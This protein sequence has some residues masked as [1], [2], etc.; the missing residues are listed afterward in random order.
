MY[1][2]TVVMEPWNNMH[3]DEGLLKKERENTNETC[4]QNM[5]AST[6]MEMVVGEG[7]AC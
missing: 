2:G 4:W 1:M 7:G 6:R 5:C 3:A